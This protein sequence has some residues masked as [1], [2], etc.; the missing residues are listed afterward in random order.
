[1][2]KIIY[3]LVLLICT[4]STFAEVTALG[5]Q[6]L[7]ILAGILQLPEQDNRTGITNFILGFQAGSSFSRANPIVLGIEFYFTPATDQIAHEQ[8]KNHY[9]FYQFY[10]QTTGIWAELP[11]EVF[12]SNTFINLG[13]R[14]NYLNYMTAGSTYDPEGG[15]QPLASISYEFYHMM[16]E[17]RLNNEFMQFT[18]GFVY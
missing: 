2:K 10:N 7:G 15:F 17:A 13:A 5:T 14:L 9:V 1:M 4:S 3:T 16:I 12:N 8:S 6:R 18:F 11:I